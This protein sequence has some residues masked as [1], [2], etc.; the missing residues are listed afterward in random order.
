MVEFSYYIFGRLARRGKIGRALLVGGVAEPLPDVDARAPRAGGQGFERGAIT[1]RL[2]RAVELAARGF[3]PRRRIE[4]RVD[5]GAI[6]EL[7][8]QHRL[9]CALRKNL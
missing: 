2:V 4:R 3:R 6:A 5:G 7:G 9:F 1:G 8:D